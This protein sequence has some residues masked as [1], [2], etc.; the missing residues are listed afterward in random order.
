VTAGW[1]SI[2][3]LVQAQRAD[4]AL[5][6]AVLT[7]GGGREAQVVTIEEQ[8]EDREARLTAAGYRP[9]SVLSVAARAEELAVEIAEEQ[10]RIERAEKTSRYWHS[11]F[12]QGRIGVWEMQEHLPADSGDPARLARLQGQLDTVQ[13][14][15]TEAGGAVERATR[16]A[17]QMTAGTGWQAQRAQAMEQ[18][19]NERLAQRA[20][21]NGEWFR[22]FMTRHHTRELARA[23]AGG[24]LAS[25]TQCRELTP[26]ITESESAAICTH[27][28]TRASYAATA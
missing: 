21:E 25:C 19:G 26:D 23:Q 18:A 12:E 27:R 6:E 14:A 4:A 8:L 1:G 5:H 10:R 24:P 22:G 16:M 11:M 15:A 3:D 7:R 13:Q 9:E 2:A 28:G 17:A 20:A